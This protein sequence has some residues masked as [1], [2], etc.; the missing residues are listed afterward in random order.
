MLLDIF[1]NMVLGEGFLNLFINLLM[2]TVVTAVLL[3]ISRKWSSSVHSFLLMGMII[4]Y[5]LIIVWNL[6]NFRQPDNRYS[7]LSFTLSAQESETPIQSFKSVKNY[8]IEDSID[9][10][11]LF[12]DGDISPGNSET[13]KAISLSR[14]ILPGA[15]IAGFIWMGG[16]MVLI[17]QL[18]VNLVYLRLFKGRLLPV[19]DI[20]MQ[21]L[22]RQVTVSLGLKEPPSLFYSSEVESPMTIGIFDP[23]IVLPGKYLNVLS[24]EECLCILS[25]ES[26]H[27]MQFDN[28][29]GIFQRIFI[30]LN[31]WNPLAYIISAKYSL[32][33]EDV[34]DHYAVQ[35]IDNPIRYT[36]CLVNLAE[37]SCLISSL[38]SAVGLIGCKS[39][40]AQRLNRILEKENMMTKLTIRTKILLTGLCAAM[41]LACAGIQTGLAQQKVKMDVQKYKMEIKELVVK[42]EQLKAAGRTKEAAELMQKADVLRVELDR[43]MSDAQKKKIEQEKKSKITAIKMQIDELQEKAKILKANGQSDQA[44]ELMTK[45]A[46]LEKEFQKLTAPAQKKQNGPDFKSKI[47]AYEKDIEKLMMK[48]DYLKENGKMEEAKELFMKAKVLKVEMDKFI[49]EAEK[50]EQEQLLKIDVEKYQQKIQDFQKQADYLKANGEVK[51]ADALKKEIEELKKIVAQRKMIKKGTTDKKIKTIKKVG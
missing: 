6:V 18:A 37:K 9:N 23:V 8:V 29:I 27:I 49:F 11:V 40:L 21:Q 35:M 16:S 7:L 2:L 1:Y 43:I 45:A 38:T 5:L 44:K 51:K 32:T 28:L 10:A 15:S 25:H 47:A 33:R 42:A 22:L 30:A 39:S 34:C 14:L 31:W 41:I 17:I 24:E 4:S 20:R 46:V 36:S 48:A 50:K 12:T 3:I 19:K 13:K 26:A